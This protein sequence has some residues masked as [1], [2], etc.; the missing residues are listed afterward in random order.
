MKKVLTE[1]LGSCLRMSFRLLHRKKVL[2]NS[3]ISQTFLHLQCNPLMTATRLTKQSFR[4]TP[5]MMKKMFVGRYHTF[6]F[7]FT[8]PFLQFLHMF[9]MSLVFQFVGLIEEPYGHTYSVTEFTNSE[10][11]F[12]WRLTRDQVSWESHGA[13]I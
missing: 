6:R 5:K 4:A 13:V 8:C 12:T 9:Q 3:G 1:T 11:D 7:F 2:L 10:V